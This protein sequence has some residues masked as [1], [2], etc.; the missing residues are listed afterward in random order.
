MSAGAWIALA[1][2][3]GGA[4]LGLWIDRARYGRHS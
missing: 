2:L 1:V 3:V 4:L